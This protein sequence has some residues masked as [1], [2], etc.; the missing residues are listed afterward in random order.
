MELKHPKTFAQMRQRAGFNRTFM[1][2]KQVST[3]QVL[4]ARQRFNRTFMEL[5]LNQLLLAEGAKA[6]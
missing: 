3:L 4:R 2:L 6:L 5:K 1:E